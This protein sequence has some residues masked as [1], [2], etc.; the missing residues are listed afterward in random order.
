MK[1]SRDGGQPEVH[2]YKAGQPST[3]SIGMVT[4]KVHTREAGRLA[5][6]TDTSAASIS[7]ATAYH[8]WSSMP[9]GT[10]QG[11]SSQAQ[12]K[13]HSDQAL[14]PH[15]QAPSR[16]VP[17]MARQLRQYIR[18]LPDSHKLTAMFCTA[19]QLV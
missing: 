15:R 8:I 9:T 13:P 6:S 12:H 1:C 11:F 5:P 4:N 19:S 18:M 7:S 14:H 16:V 17:W 3:R 10:S 2:A